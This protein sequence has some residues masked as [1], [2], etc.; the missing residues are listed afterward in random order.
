MVKIFSSRQKKSWTSNRAI[1]YYVKRSR[2]SD[3]QGHQRIKVIS[4][5][6]S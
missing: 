1:N 2:S 5:Y 3:Y 6:T 4:L